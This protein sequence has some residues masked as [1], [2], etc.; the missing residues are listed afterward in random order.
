MT[1]Q[2]SRHGNTGITS[3]F[4]WFCIKFSISI[5]S[6]L[7]LWLWFA[8]STWCSLEVFSDFASKLTMWLIQMHIW[9]RFTRIANYIQLKHSFNYGITELYDFYHFSWSCFSP[10]KT[11]VFAK[12]DVSLNCTSA[13]MHQCCVCCK[14]Q[15]TKRE[16]LSKPCVLDSCKAK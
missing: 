5:D 14:L 3:Y 4:Y 15:K 7:H 6:A 8:I 10:W 9:V 11:R 12:S 16:N 13:G 2:A 1:C